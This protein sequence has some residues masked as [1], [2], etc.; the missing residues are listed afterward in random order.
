MVCRHAPAG[1]AARSLFHGQVQHDQAVLANR[2]EHRRVVA[3]RHR[4]HAVVWMA[5]ASAP[6][7]PSRIA[8]PRSS[9]RRRCRHV[10]T[11]RA[12][13]RQLS[14][15]STDNINNHWQPPPTLTAIP[16][17]QAGAVN[18]HLGDIY[19][20]ATRRRRR[21]VAHDEIG[22]NT[23]HLTLRSSPDSHRPGA[24]PHRRAGYSRPRQA[25]S[26]WTSASRPVHRR[27]IGPC[28]PVRPERTLRRGHAQARE[29]ARLSAAPDVD[30]FERDVLAAGDRLSFI[31]VRHPPPTRPRPAAL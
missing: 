21:E 18:R 4:L 14:A 15:N 27:N 16:F 3:L 19:M 25:F 10:G 20:S 30:R 29:P 23:N 26:S 6:L 5:S 22:G 1:T 17:N 8:P 31:N 7:Q 24:M 2:V 13:V 11:F 28:R 12:P 9:S